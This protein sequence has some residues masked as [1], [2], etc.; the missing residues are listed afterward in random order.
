MAQLEQLKG[1]VEYLNKPVKMEG[2]LHQKLNG[3]VTL[4]DVEMVEGAKIEYLSSDQWNIEYLKRNK[5]TMKYG[6]FD[7]RDNLRIAKIEQI[8]VRIR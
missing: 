1:I 7:D 5:E 6:I 4:N 8:Q 2:V 3:T